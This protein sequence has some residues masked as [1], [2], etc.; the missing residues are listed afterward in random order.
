MKEN[1]NKSSFLTDLDLSDNINKLSIGNDNSFKE[2]NR[3][4]G[5]SDT[6]PKVPGNKPFNYKVHYISPS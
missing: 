1:D 2:I 5:R 3:D 4:K 6:L